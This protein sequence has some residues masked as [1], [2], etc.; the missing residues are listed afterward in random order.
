MKYRLCMNN[1]SGKFRTNK[2][3]K[4]EPQ[5]NIQ[6]LK[7]LTIFAM[8]SILHVLLVPALIV[9]QLYITMLIEKFQFD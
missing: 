8:R 2:T 7:L 5:A 9:M 1:S 4:T 3:T 6:R